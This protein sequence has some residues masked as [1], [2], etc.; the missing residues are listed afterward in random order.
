MGD[1]ENAAARPGGAWGSALRVPDFAAIRSVGFEP[2]GQVFGAAV[3]YLSTVL[4][5]GCPGT[6]AEYALRDSPHLP[7]EGEGRSPAP[8]YGAV[9]PA[10]KVAQGLYEGRHTAIERMT[11]QAAEL[12]GHGIVGRPRRIKEI[13]SAALPAGAIEFTVIGTAVRASGCLPL[14]RPFAS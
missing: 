10:A 7:G 9:D 8:V 13:P 3:Y 6:S 1:G 14:R 4:G 5:A 12:G 11:D 2:V